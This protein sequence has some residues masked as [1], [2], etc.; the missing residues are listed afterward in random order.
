MASSNRDPVV[1]SVD[2]DN[3]PIIQRAI[4]VGKTVADLVKE[5]ERSGEARARSRLA[6]KMD[7]IRCY[8][9]DL[10][11]VLKDCED[12]NDDLRKALQASEKRIAEADGIAKIDADARMAQYTSDLQARNA[13]MVETVAETVEKLKRDAAARV[14]AAEAHADSQIRELSRDRDRNADMVGLARKLTQ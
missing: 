8:I 11:L 13:Q 4:A 2:G 5:S 14:A 10:E 3:S 1:G 9:N 12:E 7:D 6:S